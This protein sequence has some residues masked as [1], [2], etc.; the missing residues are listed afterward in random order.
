[1]FK[2]CL[3]CWKRTD[4]SIM[5]YQYYHCKMK[6]WQTGKGE[7]MEW[8]NN[9]QLYSVNSC[10]SCYSC[11][12]STAVDYSVIPLLLLSLFVK[13]SFSLVH[14]KMKRI[15]VYMNK[16][17]CECTLTHKCVHACTYYTHA[18]ICTYACTCTHTHKCVCTH[19][20]THKCV[21][22]CTYYTHA[23]ICT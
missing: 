9:Q 5:Q 21:H 6:A 15:H 10:Y 4:N 11:W 22:A 23:H 7:V 1:M 20:H 14:A 17:A 18:R 19:A 13:L 3:S 12:L 16:H 2:T 8:L